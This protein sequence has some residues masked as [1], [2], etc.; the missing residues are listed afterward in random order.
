LEE[1]SVLKEFMYRILVLPK[2]LRKVQYE[3]VIRESIPA[4]FL[5]F[6]FLGK[7]NIPE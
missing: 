5:D 4:Y 7:L 1:A 2:I 6:S 3:I